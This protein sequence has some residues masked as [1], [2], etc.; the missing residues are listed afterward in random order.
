MSRDELPIFLTV[1]QC[2]KI[3]QVTERY[4]REMIRL[5]K[6]PEVFRVGRRIRIHQDNFFSWT[7]PKNGASKNV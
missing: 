7:K 2:A 6:G 4:L 5:K 1:K 3:L